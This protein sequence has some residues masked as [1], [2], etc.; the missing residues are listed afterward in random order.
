METGKLL[1]G[2]RRGRWQTSY[3]HSPCMAPREIIKLETAGLFIL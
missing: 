1:R 3:P 2:R